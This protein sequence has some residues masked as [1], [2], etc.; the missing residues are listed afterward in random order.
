MLKLLYTG[1]NIIR[2]LLNF[3]TQDTILYVNFYTFIHRIQSDMFVEM[4]MK[5]NFSKHFNDTL[6][7]ILHFAVTEMTRNKPLKECR[8][9]PN[10]PGN[11]ESNTLCR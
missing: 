10:L 6:I 11:K 1:Y 5:E 3:Y 9:S 4:N 8:L 7:I 2:Q